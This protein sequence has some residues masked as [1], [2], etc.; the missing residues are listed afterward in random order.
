LQNHHLCKHLPQRDLYMTKL[1]VPS[2]GVKFLLISFFVCL[3]ASNAFSSIGSDWLVSNSSINGNINSQIAVNH[4]YAA[5]VETLLTLDALGDSDRVE[6]SNALQYLQ[7]NISEDTVNIALTL[8]AQA[9]MGIVNQEL[10]DELID[11]VQADGGFSPFKD[12]QSNLLDTIFALHALVKIN[13]RSPLLPSLVEYIKSKQQAN[14]GFKLDLD[15]QTSV[16]I[17][18]QASLALQLVSSQFELDNELNAVT[19]YI[20]SQRNTTDSTASD[21]Q[22]WQTNWETALALLAIV[23]VNTDQVQYQQAIDKLNNAQLAN[24]SWDE[25]VYTTA[26][27]LRIQAI[28]SGTIFIPPTNPSTVFGTII[29][30]T[31]NQIISAVNIDINTTPMRQT[32]SSVNGVFSFNNL[33][34]GTYQ[35]SLSAI[36]YQKRTVDINVLENQTLN[37]GNVKLYRL[38]T[39]G[40]LQ[41][42]VTDINSAQPLENAQISITGTNTLNLQTNQQGQYLSDLDTGEINIEVSLA[43]YE[44]VTVS[45]TVIAGQ[46]LN[47]SPAL[48]T[49][50][51]PSPTVSQ[52]YGQVINSQTSQPVENATISISNLSTQLSDNNGYFS[53]TDITPQAVDILISKE[54]YNSIVIN[55]NLIPGTIDLGQIRLSEVEQATTVTLSGIVTDSENNLPIEGASVLNSSTGIIVQTDV[56]GFYQIENIKDLE[57]DLTTTKTDYFSK[58]THVTSSGFGLVELNYTLTPIAPS[59]LEILSMISN[60]DIYYSNE[61]VEIELILKNSSNTAIGTRLYIKVLNEIGEVIENE[62]VK[63]VPLGGDPADAIETVPANNQLVVEVPWFTRFHP[64][65]EY[66]IIIAAK[67]ESDSITHDESNTVVSLLPTKSVGGLVK[68]DPPVMQFDP[69]K[70]VNIS[71]TL[72]NTGN[73]PT[74]NFDITAKIYLTAKAENPPD[75]TIVSTVIPNPFTENT[76]YGID[77][78]SDGKI[79]IASN[80]IILMYDPTTNTYSEFS[81]GFVLAR[82]VSVNN[83]GLVYVLDISKRAIVELDQNGNVIQ[84]FN[85]GIN[86]L[87]KIEALANGKVLFNS[88]SGLHELN[89][90]TGLIRTIAKNNLN[91]AEGI[92]M[93]NNGDIFVA[94]ETNGSIF[95]F[96]GVE[97]SLFVEG[98]S[99]PHGLTLDADGT[100]LVTEWD[101]GKLSR[102]DLSG[103][104]T[105][106]TEGINNPFDVKVTANGSY[107]VSSFADH[108]I[109][110]VFTDGTKQKIVSET[111]NAPTL[112]VY[113]HDGNYF[114]YNSASRKISKHN[115]DGSIEHLSRTFIG[116]LDLVIDQNNKLL[117]LLR[118]SI[119]KQNGQGGFDIVAT[120]K[121]SYSKMSLTNIVDELIV[122]DGKKIRSISL[123]SSQATEIEL[124]NSLL[125]NFTS[126]GNG[127]ELLYQGSSGFY[128][129]IDNN[130]TI[131]Q[132]STKFSYPISFAKDSN[133]NKFIAELYTKKIFKIDALNN[134]TEF[135]QL[136]RVA[137]NLITLSD[138]SV[139]YSDRTSKL[140]LYDGTT[141]LEYAQLPFSVKAD[142]RMFIDGFGYIWISSGDNNGGLLKVNTGNLSVEHLDLSDN[143]ITVRSYSSITKDDLGGVYLG[144]YGKVYHFDGVTTSEISLTGVPSNFFINNLSFHNGNLWLSDRYGKTIYITDLNGN[145]IKKTS[146]NGVLYDVSSDGNNIL[147]STDVHILKFASGLNKLPDVVLSGRYSRL[148]SYDNDTLILLHDSGNIFSFNKNTSVLTGLLTDRLSTDVSVYNNHIKAVQNRLNKIVDFDINA[149]ILNS[150]T[151]IVNPKGIAISSNGELYNISSY[152]IM[153]IRS[154][155]Y[156]DYISRIYNSNYLLTSNNKLYIFSTSRIYEIDGITGSS[157]I[158]TPVPTLAGFK[159]LTFDSNSNFLFS[160]SNGIVRVKHDGKATKLV[161]TLNGIVD[162]DSKNDG[163]ILV[164]TSV[165]GSSD[166]FLLSELDTVRTLPFSLNLPG[167]LNS[168]ALI[169]DDIYFSYD[170]RINSITHVN[171][172]GEVEVFPN[173][174]SDNTVSKN[175]IAYDK[176]TLY[177]TEQFDSKNRILK[178]DFVDNSNT[179]LQIGSLIYDSTLSQSNLEINSSSVDINI[180]DLKLPI[181]GSYTVELTTDM[182]D[183]SFDLTNTVSASALASGDVYLA[184]QEVFPGNI[185][186]ETN[187]SLESIDS[188]SVVEIRTDQLLEI[189][190][191]NIYYRNFVANDE[192]DFFGIVSG[193]IKKINHVDGVEETIFDQ[194]IIRDIRINNQAEI[195]IL[196][197]TSPY[198]IYQISTEGD[199]LNVIETIGRPSFIDV[200]Q[201]G[202]IYLYNGSIYK[203]SNTNEW[204]FLSIWTGPV[205]YFEIGDTGNIYISDGLKIHKISSDGKQRQTILQDFRMENEAY[206]MEVMCFDNLMFTPMTID[207]FPSIGGEEHTLIHFDPN[208]GIPRLLFDAEALGIGIIDND[209]M[210][211]DRFNNR[212]L[213]STDY[214]RYGIFSM[215]IYCGSMTVETH[216]ITRPDV[217]VSL[218]GDTPIPQSIIENADGTK[219]YIWKFEDVGID[220]TNLPLTANFNNL[221]EGETR[222]VFAK[223]YL[224]FK[225]TLIPN[226]DLQVPLD[227]PS[228]HASSAKTLGIALDNTQYT[229]DSDVNIVDSVVN[230]SGINFTG[231]IS[232]HIETE[233]GVFVENIADVLVNNLAAG[234][235]INLPALWNTAYYF[236]G[237]Y[238]VV[239]QLLDENGIEQDAQVQ[240]FTIVSDQING[241]I[242]SLSIISDKQVYKSIDN[243]TL[244]TTVANLASNAILNDTRVQVMLAQPDGMIVYQN[245]NTVNNLLPQASQVWQ[246]QVTFNNVPTGQYFA[247]LNLLDAND[248]IISAA[249][250]ALEVVRDDQQFLHGSV[251]SLLPQVDTFIDN[252]CTYNLDN[253]DSIAINNIEI[254]QKLVNLVTQEIV[255]DDVLQTDLSALANWTNVQFIETFNLTTSTYACIITTIIDNNE[256]VFGTAIFNLTGFNHLRGY[257]WD[258]N[259]GNGIEDSG[260]SRIANASLRLLDSTATEIETIQTQTDGTYEFTPIVNGDY[261]I[262]VLNTGVL[263]GFSVTTTNNPV[264]FNV[265]GNNAVNN[266]G[267][268]ALNGSVEGLIF[269]DINGNS[270]QDINEPGIGNVSLNLNDANSLLV[271]TTTTDANGTFSFV[272]LLAA[273][274]NITVTDDLLILNNSLLTTSNVPYATTVQANQVDNQAIFGYQ[275]HDSTISGSI[276]DDINGDGILN[277]NETGLAGVD[278]QL[279]SNTQTFSTT[280]DVNGNYAFNQLIAGQYQTQITN[281]N[282]IL[283]GYQL[284]S[285]NQPY[286]SILNNHQTDSSGVFAYQAHLSVISGSVFKDDNGNGVADTGESYYTN[287]GIEL[288]RGNTSLQTLTD[289]DGTYRFQQLVAGNYSVNVIDQ[290][291][292]LVNTSLTTANQPHQINL[293]NISTDN[294]GNF[295]YQLHNS[296]ITGLVFVDSNG[297]G[298]QEADEQGLAGISIE[299]ANNNVTYNT[300]SAAD[301]RYNFNQLIADDYQITVTDTAGL[302]LETQLTTTNQPLTITLAEN[303]DQN[304]IFF[305]YQYHNSSITGKVFNDKNGNGVFDVSETYFTN[306]N[307]DLTNTDSQDIITTQT[308]TNG[309][310]EFNQLVTGNYALSVTDTDLINNWI[311][312]SSNNSSSISL[313]TSDTKTI[314]F[315]FGQ[316]DIDANVL[317][318]DGKGRLLIL[319]NP[320]INTINSN[321]CIGIHSWSVATTIAE[322]LSNTTLITAKLYNSSGEL[323]EQETTTMANFQSDID[324]QSNVTES[325][326]ILQQIQFGRLSI[327]ITTDNPDEFSILNNDYHVELQI[328][329][330]NNSYNLQSQAVSASCNTTQYVGQANGDF[331]FSEITPVPKPPTD[332]PNGPDQA[333][334]L[335]QQKVFLQNV[336][337]AAAWSYT[338]TENKAD[339][340]TQFE[341]GEYVMY[342]IFS[343]NM[344]FSEDFQEELAEVMESGEG[345]IIATGNDNRNDELYDALGIEIKGTHEGGAQTIELYDSPLHTATEVDVKLDEIVLKVELDDEA[346]SVGQFT[347]TQEDD[348]DKLNAISFIENCEDQDDDDDED[349]D[350]SRLNKSDDDDDDDDDEDECQESENGKGIFAAFDLLLQATH[351]KQASVYSEILQNAIE[352]LHNTV[353]SGQIGKAQKMKLHIENLGIPFVGQVRFDL[354]TGLKLTRTNH[355]FTQVDDTI[356]IEFDTAINADFIID[357]WF[358]LQESPQTLT[359]EILDPNGQILQSIATTL[360]ATSTNNQNE[361]DD[362]DD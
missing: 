349:E 63:H 222:S 164:G 227:I 169:N 262:E 324:G 217:D 134:V 320:A 170:A 122:F 142:S 255:L 130:Y 125:T 157:Q 325:N 104:I 68:F 245:I 235:Q 109:Y 38:T 268:Q 47:F 129:E 181:A 22:T 141:E 239:S 204:Q 44:T 197:L 90:Q 291:A 52:L 200:D 145:L 251:V 26:L 211:Y 302:L 128:S 161:S 231:V 72:S 345:L 316:I 25:D 344:S 308:G 172:I 113:D 57:F 53:Y 289:N 250:T 317:P 112:V 46:T 19:Q 8:I 290:N 321:S 240:I 123:N 94:D 267:L 185:S 312:T 232:Q 100:L 17:S 54:G 356:S 70:Q 20:L 132:D 127:I 4:D 318:S 86:S 254:H 138:G 253:T 322:P 236:A 75:N 49:S 275:Y 234:A 281:S 171:S 73:L 45:A 42:V 64:A 39:K 30:E 258:D 315:A 108:S 66:T 180:A 133:G 335:I 184:Q 29:D 120:A 5:T 209:S 79:L 309:Q 295:G 248:V 41:G 91:D 311:N 256:Q 298:T 206:S 229:S 28:L 166:I 307:L 143:S 155:G 115:L 355:V 286:L 7:N 16:Y 305:G 350:K 192:G 191:S 99:R 288:I 2:C 212:I 162:M 269:S 187:V 199:I 140:Y 183:I 119:Y 346:Q 118:N 237:N 18:A 266:F 103:N 31:N 226:Q 249:T 296:S 9:Q 294:T 117:V 246:H 177:A 329:T 153:K 195:F 96:D 244:S 135:A 326:L 23:N 33:Q 106:I 359:I 179:G 202:N 11:R 10:N 357:M 56:N 76:E 334:E 260:E 101:V 50:G 59:E 58:T 283:N 352:Y 43:G 51:T 150:Y 261:Q 65:G 131:S 301:G 14:G 32:Q 144:S 263:A 34:A 48:S 333:A 216:I 247:T 124:N 310:Y 60:R 225:N 12:Y 361:D 303:Q 257:I 277:N 102:I 341:T 3:Y 271:A 156:G 270:I 13:P 292:V 259:N 188:K 158:I 137:Y 265:T 80:K 176:N 348:D 81:S 285:N 126:N 198:N 98:L 351:L 111:I 221:L 21:Y 319:L 89:T 175:I 208:F 193:Q 55:T 358:V 327:Q 336:L 338:I 178:L 331:E 219:E 165:S 314:D 173:A 362:D 105:T 273:D 214:S 37:I 40:I 230:N 194:E 323:L 116:A 353:V 276:F 223:A 284:T 95:K 241:S 167:Y 92:V 114:I 264:S 233:Q 152:G 69:N 61:E 139:V 149:N 203:S 228:V 347:G 304:N 88:G 1:T 339:F 313:T 215:P 62:P 189:S 218:N 74:G 159:G 280:S 343:E 238:Q 196:G 213:L 82:D 148:E 85:L 287:V 93:T 97:L 300:I 163:S 27:A 136:T 182:T 24:G 36:G 84:A 15:E 207:A 354:P 342:A 297:N 205:W 242:A 190:N 35:L 252:N 279:Q 154:D 107:Y 306:I 174:F 78:T 360:T 87:K 71:A 340:K 77:K 110:E 210:H 330:L 220:T 147:V 272:E 293:A 67:N 6:V 186:V 299:I 168:I 121:Q 243:V 328:D 146:I 224:Q 282:G 278:I 160:S 337:D 201:E 274:Y 151:G 332:D 83:I